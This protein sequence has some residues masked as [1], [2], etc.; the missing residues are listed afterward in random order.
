MRGW[1]CVCFL[2]VCLSL[3]L[4]HESTAHHKHSHAPERKHTHTHTHTYTHTHTHT[5][6]DTHIHTRM[7]SKL[8][9]TL[10]AILFCRG[11]S[12]LDP[13]QRPPMVGNSHVRQPLSA[14]AN[15]ATGGRRAGE[16]KQPDLEGMAVLAAFYAPW[17]SK[18]VGLLRSAPDVVLRPGIVEDIKAHWMP[19]P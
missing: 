3:H 1:G 2:W 12:G 10:P 9:T 4:S 6:T 13:S 14:I 11:C 17:N 5:F 8:S 16:P 18:L 19:H 15:G 7:L